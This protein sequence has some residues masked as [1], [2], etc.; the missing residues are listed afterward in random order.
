MNFKD[1]KLM[2]KTNLKFANRKLT[3]KNENNIFTQTQTLIKDTVE[4]IK[5]AVFRIRD[6]FVVF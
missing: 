5:E 4:E 6:N 2:N 1:W 3:S